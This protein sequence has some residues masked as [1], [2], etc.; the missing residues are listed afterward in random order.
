IEWNADHSLRNLALAHRDLLLRDEIE[1]Q[2]RLDWSAIISSTALGSLLRSA[3]PTTHTDYQP[4][5]D[6]LAS[7]P[8]VA[9]LFA[10]MPLRSVVVAPIIVEGAHHGVILLTSSQPR[11]YG[12]ADLDLVA[13]LAG[14]IGM[15]FDTPVLPMA[16]PRL[17]HLE[18]FIMSTPIGLAFRD[19]DLRYAWVNQTVASLAGTSTAAFIGRTTEEIAP[20]YAEAVEPLTR[21]VLETGETI[22]GVEVAFPG[23]VEGDSPHAS[24]AF[25]F[26]V[27]NAQF[28]LIGV[29]AAL[30]PDAE[31]SAFVAPS[32]PQSTPVRRSPSMW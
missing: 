32:E 11:A 2:L 10:G 7:S 9:L 4:G 6:D 13:A 20:A 15:M 17:P 1:H 27:K 22:A 5:P 31:T 24:T 3:E 23:N 16:E 26:P 14:V 12:V 25:Y 8:G 30:V 29:G 19:R 28:E 21:H 18:E